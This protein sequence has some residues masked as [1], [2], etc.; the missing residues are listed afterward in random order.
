MVLEEEDLLE[1]IDKSNPIHIGLCAI[2]EGDLEA[3]MA[4]AK[5]LSI[6]ISSA[7]AEVA[8]VGGWLSGYGRRDRAFN[9]SDLMVLSY[10]EPDSET[11]LKDNLLATYADL[12][13]SR[14][15]F[16]DEESHRRVEGW[17][18]ALTV[19]GRLYDPELAT[20]KATTLLDS[21]VLDSN[22]TV[23]KVL[24]ICGMLGFSDQAMNLAD[25]CILQQIFTYR[26]NRFA[27]I[28]GPPCEV[29][30]KLW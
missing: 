7:V 2:F 11:V 23:D 28:R 6:T 21:I 30:A 1:T 12:L 13:A 29:R 8:S 18:L 20:T 15:S 22:S 19:L 17:Q 3:F 14:E 24:E 10:G 5:H 4:I 9:K 25:V 27:E 16:Y 26:A